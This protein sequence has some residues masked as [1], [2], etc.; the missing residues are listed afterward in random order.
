MTSVYYRG[1]QGALI[2]Y[3]VTNRWTFD[4]K[5]DEWV[6]A[7]KNGAPEKV[8]IILVGNKIDNEANR[9]VSTVEG[10][11]CAKRLGLSFFEISAKEGTCIE[12]MFNELGELVIENNIEEIKIEDQE[13]TTGNVFLGKKFK[14]HKCFI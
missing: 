1:A 4:G 9:Q 11:E 6:S 8:N 7:V 3:D 14:R 10:K 2:F 5:I 12:E 13:T